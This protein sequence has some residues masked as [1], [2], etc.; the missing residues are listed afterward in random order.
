VLVDGPLPQAVEA[1]LVPAEDGG[2]ATADR[3]HV[4]VA[5]MDMRRALL[6]YHGIDRDTLLRL[7]QWLNEQNDTHV[8]MG[9]RS[10]PRHRLALLLDA[11]LEQTE[12][13]PLDAIEPLPKAS[14]AAL[15]HELVAAAIK[16]TGK[17]MEHD[18]LKKLRSKGLRAFPHPLGTAKQLNEKDHP[19][20]EERGLLDQ[21]V[22]NLKKALPRDGNDNIVVPAP[23][24]SV[25][26]WLAKELPETAKRCVL[27][28]DALV[29]TANIGQEKQ[30]KALHDRMLELA[31]ATNRCATRVR[32]LAAAAA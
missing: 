29:E 10:L 17:D 32:H 26:E 1:W 15:S 2:V 27:L 25:D 14:P 3:L 24:T 11:V 4:D 6:Q 19:L 9:G 30:R 23:Y 18:K 22:N 16:Q 21:V 28:G 20:S 31:E 13:E 12:I 5:L 7:R 8:L